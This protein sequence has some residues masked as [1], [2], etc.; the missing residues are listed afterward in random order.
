MIG[1][2]ITDGKQFKER[3]LNTALRSNGKIE[4]FASEKA[5]RNFI[6]SLEEHCGVETKD[7]CPIK[8]IIKLAKV[9][10]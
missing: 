4:I 8:V 2:I 10:D 3:I 6:G 9:E 7:L 5:A 1:Y